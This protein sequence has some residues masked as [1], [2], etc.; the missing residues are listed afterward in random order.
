MSGPLEDILRI[1]DHVTV[2]MVGEEALIMDLDRLHTYS[3]NETAAFI[4]GRIDGSRTVEDIRNAVL[5]RY[6]ISP[7]ECRS[8]VKRLI[9]T[10]ITE[11]LV[12]PA[13]SH[14]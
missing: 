4:V 5:E 3:L 10:L 6:E 7:G 8:R 11:H 1:R 9:E 2:R 13:D 12:V 14:A